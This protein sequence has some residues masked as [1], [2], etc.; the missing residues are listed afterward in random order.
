MK[1]TEPMTELGGGL[2]PL[3]GDARER[4]ARQLLLKELG[5]EG[6]R[7]IAAAHFLVI[8]AGGLGSPAL[9][10]L[11]AAGAGAITVVD[12]DTVSVSNLSRQVLHTADR[13]GVNKALS[14]K[15]ALASV[16][17]H[18]RVT[19]VAKVA[20]EALL[21]SLARECDV[22]LDCTDNLAARIA[23][24]RA[25]W[26]E[27]RP[28]VFASAIRWSAQLSVF[29]PRDPASPCYECV[30][31]PDDAANDVKASAVG[32]WSPLTGIIGTMQAGEALKIA[33]GIGSPLVGRMLF[34]DLLRM[35]F[36]EIR[37]APRAGCRCEKGR[38]KA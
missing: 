13:V 4:V 8:G 37:I 1:E 10:Y 17:P 21:R 16:N 3:E 2:G 5:E 28:L 31:E 34:A 30:F 25:A 29:D 11:A 7:R 36:D 24:S 23:V 35:R 14:A 33:A 15:E 9:L 26:D 20:D 6:Q 22:V 18:C 27:G 19:A 32:V 12:G 38:K